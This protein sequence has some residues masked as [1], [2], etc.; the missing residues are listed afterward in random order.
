VRVAIIDLGTNSVRFDVNQIGPGNRVTRLHR[1]KLMVRLGQNLFTGGKLDPGAIRRTLQA[2]TS[3]EHTASDLQAKKIIAFGTSALREAAD[4]DKL[5]NQIRA[6]TGIDVRVISGVE[7]ARLIASGILANEKFMKER[8]GLIDIGGGSTEICICRGREVSHSESFSLGAARLQQVFLKSSPPLS[9]KPG[10]LSPV[11]QLRRHIRATLLSKTI[12]EEWPRT[13]K[14]WGSSGTIR[15][16][17][18]L[19]KKTGGKKA[20]NKK[21]GGGKGIEYKELKK[22]VKTMSTM[23]TTQ[24]LGLPGMEARRVDMILA[25]AILLEECM[26][27][28]GIKK[29]LP[30]EYSLR[31][32]ILEEEIRV[33]Q[34]D[35]SSN[36]PFH[37]EDIYEKAAKFATTPDDEAHLKQTVALSESLF[38]RLKRLHKL[39]REWRYY[40]TAASI[41]HDVGEAISRNRHGVHSYY[42]VKNADFPSMQNWEAEFVGQL[43]LWHQD[44][45][46][47]PKSLPFANDKV[48]RQA[49]QRLLAILRIADALD[50]SRKHMVKI[51]GVKVAKTKVRILLTTRGAMDLELLRVEQKKNLF[52]EVFKRELVVERVGR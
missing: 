11:E 2:F 14:A 40:L 49:F 8:F 4:S 13:N 29:V 7:E 1:E 48:K 23:T 16:L 15:A 46:I 42:I 26:A 30:T 28:L 20:S 33:Y 38:D 39:G 50:R 37:L 24:L 9:P 22:L 27:A 43:C 51:A 12:S 44:G 21:A 5:L 10:A 45:K 18:K 47:D 36:I 41:L 31:D 6:R 3:F 35:N 25:G 32:G 34:Q 17:A 19:I 52:E